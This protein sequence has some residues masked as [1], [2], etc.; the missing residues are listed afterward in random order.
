MR[1]KSNNTL[2]FESFFIN[3]LAHRLELIGVNNR[4]I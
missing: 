1:L 3:L 4:K 2:V